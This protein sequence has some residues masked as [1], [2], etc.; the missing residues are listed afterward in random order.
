MRTI[1]TTSAARYVLNC[2]FHARG[3]DR[4]FLQRYYL[5]QDSIG[6]SLACVAGGLP[7]NWVC[8]DSFV[9]KYRSEFELS[10][11]YSRRVDPECWYRAQF[12]H[13]LSRPCLSPLNCGRVRAVHLVSIDRKG[14]QT[15]LGCHLQKQHMLTG[16]LPA[17]RK[18]E[19]CIAL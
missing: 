15:P 3:L 18:T 5:S 10:R 8:R 12:L 13:W 9:G 4:C 6:P 11:V 19:Y 17:E 2:L 16:T 7:V 1:S 14:A